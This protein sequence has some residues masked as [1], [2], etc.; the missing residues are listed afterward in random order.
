MWL[1]G[2]LVSQAVPVDWRHLTDPFV[3]FHSSERYALMQ[4]PLCVPHTTYKHTERGRVA[5]AWAA[6]QTKTETRLYKLED[7]WRT[8]KLLDQLAQSVR[9][10]SD[11]EHCPSFD[12]GYGYFG[13]GIQYV[14]CDNERRQVYLTGWCIAIG[15]YILRLVVQFKNVHSL[16]KPCFSVSSVISYCMPT[17][18]TKEVL[19]DL[20]EQR[21]FF[22]PVWIHVRWPLTTKGH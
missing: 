22:L 16:L 15:M 5:R 3:C 12:G 4:S 17:W 6:M 19:S 13:F 18:Q 2:K 1:L 7:F 14:K 8:T 20:T 9:K 21:F 11:R 10:V